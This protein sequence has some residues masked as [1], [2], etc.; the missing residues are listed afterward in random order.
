MYLR[1]LLK[2][3]KR[4]KTMNLI[5]LLFVI[6]S[7]MFFAS[8]V[9]NIVSVMGGLDRYLDMAGMMEQVAVVIEPD[10][11][12]P[13][14]DLLGNSE[15]KNFKRE[16]ILLFTPDTLSCNGT[17]VEEPSQLFLSSVDAMTVNCYD[18]NNKPITEVEPGKVMLTSSSAKT[19]SANTGDTILI[20]VGGGKLSECHRCLCL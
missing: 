1:I 7:A 14:M 9:N 5:I 2:D 6:L 3:L 19:L 4:K 10:S 11:G 16:N 18:L 20:K 13:L 8:S 12:E 17:A 15:V